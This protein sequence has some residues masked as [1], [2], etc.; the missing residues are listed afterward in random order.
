MNPVRYVFKGN[1]HAAMAYTRY[2]QVL[3]AELKRRMTF[4]D[5]SQ[6]RSRAILIN[7]TEIVCQSIFGQDQVIITTVDVIKEKKKE[8]EQLY[9]GDDWYLLIYDGA[10]VIYN[11]V[12]EKMIKLPSFPSQYVAIARISPYANNKSYN[13]VSCPCREFPGYN[14]EIE[15]GSNPDFFNDVG[16]KEINIKLISNSS[17]IVK[18]EV[19]TVDYGSTPTKKG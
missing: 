4:Q 9:T 12:T 16:Y 5:L 11:P 3:L 18:A 17:H 1:Q 15:I 13:Y 6:D 7:G 2:G 19:V 14:W 10:S 8:K